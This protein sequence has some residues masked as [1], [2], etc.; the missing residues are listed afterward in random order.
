MVRLQTAGKQNQKSTQEPFQKASQVEP[1]DPQAAQ[2]Q[3]QLR[4]TYIRGHL[5][6]GIILSALFAGPCGLLMSVASAQMACTG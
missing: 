3:V 2:L 5:Q 1:L 4:Y 6:I